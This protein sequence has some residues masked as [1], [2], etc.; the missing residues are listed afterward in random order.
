MGSFPAERFLEFFLAGYQNG[1]I[2]GAAR[3]ELAGNLAAGDAIGGVN[4][5]ENGIAA[6]VA[7]VEGFAGNAIDG[8]ERAD[9]GIRNVQDVDIIT[10]ASA[11]RGGIVRAENIDV[12]QIASGGVQD[13]GDEMRLDAMI[14]AELLRGTGSIEIA[15][16]GVLQAG[17]GAIVRENLFE[18]QLG[19]AVGI[20]GGF[21]MVLGNGDDFRFAIGGGG[22]RKDEFLH[23]VAGDGVQ[24]VHAAGYVGGVEDAGLADGLGDQSF[25]GEMHHGVNLVLGEK[26]I[27]LGAIGEVGLDKN[28]VRGHGGTM[29]FNEAVHGDN[30]HAA[31]EQYFGADAADVSGCSSN[32][33]I[34]L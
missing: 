5:F 29:A 34:H 27:K 13:A 14:L 3:A 16:H 20:D 17:I 2:A 23:A 18:H 32:K 30:A 11:V 1:G 25:G 28:C 12:R 31:R 33:N 21:A 6:A 10:D 24:Q 22:G 7:D 19:F 4:H 8:F 9:V 15:E 26:I